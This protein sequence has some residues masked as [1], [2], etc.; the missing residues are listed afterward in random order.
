M[1]THPRLPAT[2]GAE[3]RT[4]MYSSKVGEVTKEIQFLCHNS[5]ARLLR[6][7][8]EEKGREGEGRREGEG[9]REGGRGK[10]EEGRREKEGGREGEGSREERGRRK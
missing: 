2:H 7:R 5:K 9:E 1:T 8:R 10:E 6:G 4:T 3:E